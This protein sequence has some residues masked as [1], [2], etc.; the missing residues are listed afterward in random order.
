MELEASLSL[1][2]FEALNIP[3]PKALHSAQEAQGLS[4]LQGTDL[5]RVRQA[6]LLCQ[7]VGRVVKHATCL[8]TRCSVENPLNSLAWLCDGM[9]DVLRIPNSC[10]IIL[11]HCMHGGTRDKSTRWWASD[12]VLS[13]LAMRCSRNHS[14]ASWTPSIQSKKRARFPTHEEAA[15]PQLLCERSASLLAEKHPHLSN[16]ANQA[17]KQGTQVLLERQ[18]TYAKP[19]VSMFACYDAWAVPVPEQGTVERILGLYP[20]GARVTLRKLVPWGR[21]R[22]CLRGALWDLRRLNRLPGLM[23]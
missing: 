17:A 15:Y 5:E 11:E 21:V 3:V 1:T 16:L 4:A 22:V 6:N 19:L 14:H 18:P 13:P 12:H 20:K 9:D 2:E 8:R 7:A 23:E 10:E